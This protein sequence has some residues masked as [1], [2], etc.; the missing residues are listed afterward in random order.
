MDERPKILI[1][2]DEPFNLDFLEQELDDLG[3]QAIPAQNGREALSRMSDANPDMVL[4][5]IMM[6]VMDGFE[7]LRQIQ[8]VPAWRDTPVIFVSAMTDL[9]SVARG[10]ELGAE[11]YL[12]KPFNPVILKARLGA[13]LSRKR[14]RDLE[15]KYLH[16]LERELEIGHQIQS[17]FLPRDLPQV[18]GWE[19][20]AYFQPAREVA[21][22][23]YDAFLLEDGRLGF[24]LGDVT[25]KGVGAA[26]FMSL[27]RSLL[28]AGMSMDIFS[29]QA[30]TP[31]DST[32]LLQRVVSRTN[33]YVCR[34]H[35]EALFAT[36]FVGILEPENG[37]LTYLNAGHNPALMVSEGIVRSELHSDNPLLGVFE[38]IEFQSKKIELAPGDILLVYSDGVTDTLDQHDSVF[39]T[40]GLLSLI[41]LESRP[42][43]RLIES[44]KNGLNDFRGTRAP[45]DDVTLMAI[46]KM[47]P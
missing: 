25:D 26:L 28:R 30:D 12:P 1:V 34:T 4:L 31:L 14:L 23:F 18:D 2:D 41:K 32:E 24:F 8:A 27:Y 17:G 5:D 39:G 6:P 43:S 29:A 46:Q 11:D 9:E 36:L 37:C 7:V 16:S 20:A 47:N 22:D 38:E 45:F 10:I 40:E 21:G 33:Q 13:G 44:I 3:Y 15:K 19:M 42:A 35:T